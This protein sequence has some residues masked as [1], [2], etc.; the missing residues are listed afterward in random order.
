MKIRVSNCIK[1][2][3]RLMGEK[4]VK[5]MKHTNDNFVELHIA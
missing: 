5:T 1:K 2:V 3:H 4:L